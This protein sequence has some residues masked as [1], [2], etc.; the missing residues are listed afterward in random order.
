MKYLLDTNHWSYIQQGFEPVVRK[1]TSLPPESLLLMSVVSQAELM[2]GVLILPEGRRRDALM[3]LFRESVAS[4]AELVPINSEVAEQFALVFAELRRIGRPIPT[5]DIW[6]AA[7]ARAHRLTLVS[8]D[9]HFA[10]VDGLTV[11]CWT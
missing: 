3:A 9:K 7:T 10:G 1:I 4:A 11:E 6:L 5:N 2:S 8:A